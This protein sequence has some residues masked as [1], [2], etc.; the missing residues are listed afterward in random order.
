MT[1]QRKNIVYDD[2]K[3]HVI[4]KAMQSHGEPSDAAYLRKCVEFYEQNKHG[5]QLDP[6]QIIG[7]LSRLELN[8]TEIKEMIKRGVIV[9]DEEQ[10]ESVDE[11]D[12]IFD[13]V[14]SQF[15]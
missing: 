12:D 14:L 8:Q 6:Q 13:D 4:S 5:L 1:I 3:H 15:D 2:K 10:A 11:T 7:L 9:V